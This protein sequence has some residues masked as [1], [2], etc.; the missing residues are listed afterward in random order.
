M[1]R[2]KKIILPFLFILIYS[3]GFSQFYNGHQM[4]FGK[5][6]VQFEEFEW[7]YY[8]FEKFDTY[9]YAGSGEAAMR[10]AEIAN[11][12]IGEIET[13]FEHQLSKRIVFVIYQNLSDF[14]QSNIGLD[15]GDDQ[16]N[17]GGV[18]KVIDNIAFIYIE[19]DIT[20]LR[21]QIRAAIA[22]I[23]LNEMLYGSNIRNK[24][25]NNTLISMP[26][27]YI[28][29][30]VAFVSKEWS[31]EEE[32]Q[33]KN[34]LN[35]GQ[36]KHFNQLTEENAAIA[37]HSIWN[38]IEKTYGKQVIPNIVYLTRLTKSIESGFLYVLGM[39]LKSLQTNWTEFY[40]VQ[41]DSFDYTA[42]DP[43]GESL[44]KR[45]R[46][47][48]N[49]YQVCYS[50]NSKKV[51]WAE[52]KMGKYWIK[53]K[54][55]ETNKIKTIFK[56]E[57]KLVQITDYSYP[58]I[59]WHPSGQLL[60]FI[61][62]KKGGIY[63]ITYNLETKEFK[64]IEIAALEKVS[65]F[66]YSHDGMTLVFSA[67]SYG[68]S[69]IFL[70]NIAANT[71]T[72]ITQDIADDY[73]PSYI[74]NSQQIIFTSKRKN[75]EL[76][77][78]KNNFIETQKYNDVFVYDLKSKN[79]KQIT[80]TENIQETQ[81]NLKNG[82]YTYV[83]D[84][85]GIYNFYA[86][87]IDSLISFI[88]TTTHY[89]HFL[90]TEQLTNYKYNI[91]DIDINKYNDEN[92]FSYK[93][94]NKF[95]LFYDKNFPDPVGNVKK[96]TARSFFENEIKR[97]ETIKK[98]TH[99]SSDSLG[100]RNIDPLEQPVNIDNY[101]F[102][103]ESSLITTAENTNEEFDENGRAKNPRT[104][105]YFTTFYTNYLVTQVDFSFLNNSYQPFTGNA[106]Y[107]YPGFNLIFK[108]GTSDL[109]EDYRITAGARLSANLSG[110]EYLLSF[111]SL[112]KRWNKQLILH[113]QVM[114]SD[115]DNYYT[116]K[117]FTHEA[118]YIMRYPFSQV[119]ALQFTGNFRHNHFT[120]LSLDNQSLLSKPGNE[121]WLSLKAEYIFD[122]TNELATNI[123]S[124]FRFK[125]FGEAFKQLDKKETDMFVVGC[126]FRY[127]QPIHKNLIFAARFASSYSFGSAKLIYYLGGIDNWIKLS[128]KNPI[129]DTD[130]RIDPD[131]NYVYQA[132]ATNMRGFSQNIRNGTNFAVLNTEIRWPFVS[133]FFPK[134]INNDFLK[135]LQLIGFFDIGSAWSGIT[136][137]SG[138]N[139]YQNDHYDQNSISVIIYNNNYPIVSGYGFGVRS[140]LFGYFIR[141]DWAWGLENNTILPAMFYLSLG[142]D[143]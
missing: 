13:F 130:I 76:G 110:N 92:V 57:H 59:K 133:Y 137:F 29:G 80:K 78:K 83:S 62:E 7:F 38:Y 10:T 9:F 25:A 35:S 70:F 142:L 101:D 135:N 49:Y 44:I 114:L 111:E 134:P 55:I 60:G 84:E 128:Q 115:T 28:K 93:S 106:F 46:K 120:N 90:V 99:I 65:S 21:E 98:E 4:K 124:G 20:K 37:G 141:V 105:R 43:A 26:E 116:R 117:T 89:R 91:L 66:D 31:A 19:E 63:Y 71:L 48:T 79:I 122:N 82:K 52:N 131:V 81:A 96:T 109:F 64:Q 113:R 50:P 103:F 104:H 6:R 74:N 97:E 5:N 42:E 67:F 72:N 107:F 3:A 143:F 36:F 16:Y 58:I 32:N 102:D 15:T 18:I 39:S 27:W 121:Y 139:A 132:V 136:P 30:L 33:T 40:R 140:K 11:Q 119:D 69:D 129:F 53:I 123:L 56:R 23:I 75:E 34:A 77:D 95:Q 51:A 12:S 108:V 14:R 125:I 100:N 138:N 126:D 88:D 94:N 73:N 24:I 2:L 1:Y 8:R 47:N 61:I 22:N 17:I 68:Q 85:N 86:A 112:K 54:D 127:Y 118:F 87:N 41:Y 45:S